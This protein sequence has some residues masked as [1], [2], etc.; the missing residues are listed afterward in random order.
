MSIS[1]IQDTN[2]Y[3]EEE[4]QRFIEK[5]EPEIMN[6]LQFVTNMAQDKDKPLEEKYDQVLSFFKENKPLLEELAKIVHK[7]ELWANTE[8]IIENPEQSLPVFIKQ[9]KAFMTEFSE[10][11]KQD[12]LD[13][14]EKGQTEELAKEFETYK[15]MG[16]NYQHIFI[17][18]LID[19]KSITTAARLLNQEWQNKITYG[20][21]KDIVNEWEKLEPLSEKFEQFTRS[22]L[23][24]RLQKQEEAHQMAMQHARQYADELGKAYDKPQ[25]K[26]ENTRMPMS[27]IE[28]HYEREHGMQ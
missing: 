14:L 20:T 11:L 2:N 15:N 13:K 12:W 3:S 16:E 21:D 22:Y 26:I 17:M 19:E 5:R 23:D 1:N 25:M 24:S 8:K 27:L 18:P 9:N 6:V 10:Y 7:E 28:T 4:L